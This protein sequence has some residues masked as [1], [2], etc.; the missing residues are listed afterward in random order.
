MGGCE[1]ELKTMVYFVVAACVKVEK[2]RGKAVCGEAAGQGWRAE[3][4]RGGSGEASV[5]GTLEAVAGV[6]RAS[7]IDA[8]E[9]AAGPRASRFSRL[10]ACWRSC[11]ESRAL[12][13]G[14]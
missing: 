4:A 3:Q 8:L 12:R 1:E 9:Q 14:P 5:W 2:I 11:V 7:T 10:C 6:F 13:R